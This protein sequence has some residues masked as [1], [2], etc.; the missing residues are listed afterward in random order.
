MEK[1][2]LIRF[3]ENREHLEDS[4]K[5]GFKCFSH[6]VNYQPSQ[7]EIMKV[8]VHY[9]NS[10]KRPFP[11]EINWILSEWNKHGDSTIF[12][13]NYNQK[14]KSDHLFNSNIQLIIHTA[15]SAEITMKCF[16][17]LRDNQKIDTHHTGYFGSYGIAMKKEWAIS[18]GA[19]QVIYVDKDSFLTNALGRLFAIY[20]SSVHIG[21]KGISFYALRAYFDVWSF[22]ETSSHSHEYEWRLPSEHNIIGDLD[23][24]EKRSKIINFD[25]DDICGLFVPK[26]EIDFFIKHLKNKA[27]SDGK[28][29]AIIPKVNDVEDILLTDEDR[30]KIAAIFSRK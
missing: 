7:Y 23:G 4:L 28:P 29:N 20:N 2:Y 3:D 21:S 19:S 27:I 11:S 6:K 10:L 18:K 25:I 26:D 13:D 16:T 14:R 22:F 5:S 17:E 24:F 8:L 9:W 15:G 1:S 12:W 30:E